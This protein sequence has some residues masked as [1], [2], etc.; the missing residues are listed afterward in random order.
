M[1]DADSDLAV[2]IAAA[3]AGAQVV[4]AAYG[5]QVTRRPKSDLDFATEADL[6]AE[7]AILAVIDSARP[8]DARLG[9]E[10]GATG[11]TGARR[12]LVDPLCGTLNFA[13]Q[14]PLVAVNVALLDAT[15][16]LACVCVDPIAEEC[17]WTD[18]H[19]AYLRRDGF[20]EPLVPTSRSRL[21][22]INC[23]G[24]VEEA[25]LG[26]QLLSDPAFRSAYG[27]R[28]TSTTLAVTWV[29]AGRRAAYVSDGLFRDNVHYAAGIG[30]CRSAG[31]VVTDLRG[32]PVEG[33]RGLL[34]AADEETHEH[35]ADILRSHLADG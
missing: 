6:D 33:G 26:P 35:L 7:T 4:R 23:D 21:V 15:A 25:F 27:P 13:A 19:G 5:T 3:A 8:E 30:I 9:E 34:V 32:D 20:D 29:A 31:C 16:S 1:T 18:G 17:F 2:A 22:D 24:P 11:G 28:V 10:S 14:T 12:W